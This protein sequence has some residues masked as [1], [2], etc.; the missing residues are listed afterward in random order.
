MSGRALVPTV[1]AAMPAFT[2][3]RG[4]V[5][6]RKCDCGQHTTGGACE[7]CKKKHMKL[8]R[9]AAGPAGPAVAPAIVHEVLNSS[10]QPLDAATRGFF[11]PRFAHDFSQVRVHAD[12]QA[13]ESAH[14]VNALA[15]TVGND[16]VFAHGRYA[17]QTS[18]GK[19]LLA[20]ELTHTLQQGERGLGLHKA[21]VD[22]ETEGD[23]S[24][25][26]EAEA[27]AYAVMSLDDD[28][29]RGPDPEDSTHEVV[30]RDDPKPK[31]PT[32][33]SAPKAK[34]AP[35]PK[36]KAPPKPKPKPN[37]CTRDIFY[38]GTCKGLVLGARDR[39]CD[40]KD[41]LL[42][43]DR[44]KDVDGKPCPDHKFTP[45][46]TCDHD[47]AG[48][49]KKGC[50]DTD[51][52]M[53]VPR[54]QFDRKQCGD[55]WTICA[56][57]KQTHAYVREKSVTQAKFEV[58]KR[59]V[60]DLGVPEDTFKGAAY[61]PGADQKVIDKDPCCSAS[62]PQPPSPPPRPKTRL[63]YQEERLLPEGESYA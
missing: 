62:T 37:P 18:A 33:K 17:P 63:K 21:T 52:W 39:C 22:S 10:G 11:A 51:N 50:S 29:I 19:H 31:G 53:A 60:Q 30:A 45:M 55:V 38:E 40:P 43:P 36:P 25:E 54:N 16:I 57:G 41:G 46:F 23:Q 6:Q 12:S 15:Y 3:V 2:P 20:H 34:P 9:H 58:G 32:K 27:T 4:G 48:A 1:A 14:A 35:K 5:L 28:E 56:K 47:C 44:D 49:L 42:N 7:E 13:A 8:Q 24:L 26:A 61:K 59:I